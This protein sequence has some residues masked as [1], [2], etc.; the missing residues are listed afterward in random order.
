M[1]GRAVAVSVLAAMHIV[2]CEAQPA[3][4]PYQVV[5]DAIPEPLTDTPGDPARGRAIVIK[6]EYTC[7]LCHSGPFPEERFQGNLAT[8]LRGAGT[9]WTAG[10]L[11]LRMVDATR[12]NS[13]TIMPSF[14]RVDSLNRVGSTWR[15]KPILTAQ[16]VED[17]VA[18]L[19]TLRD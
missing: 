16:Q 19:A 18:F 7:L 1:I 4:H 8:D 6:R 11:R 10:K 13:A 15:G 9:R 5:G 2:P 14:Y 17:V 12:L 3:L